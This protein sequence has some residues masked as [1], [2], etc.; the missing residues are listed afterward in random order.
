MKVWI[1]NIEMQNLQEILEQDFEDLYFMFNKGYGS[2]K[3][4][5]KIVDSFLLNETILKEL[6]NFLKEHNINKDDI[7]SNFMKPFSLNRNNITYRWILNYSNEK[8]SSLNLRKQKGVIPFDS[9]LIQTP[10]MTFIKN[11]FLNNKS[12]LISWETG[13]WKTA[14]VI[15]LLNEINENPIEDF[16]AKMYVKI[17]KFQFWVELPTNISF[18]LAKSKL[19]ECLKNDK[20]YSKFKSIEEIN[21]VI[22]SNPFTTILEKLQNNILFTI[23]NP[24]EYNFPLGSLQIEQIETDDYSGQIMNSL[25]NNPNLVYIS[26]IRRQSEY[27]DFLLASSQGKQIIST[28]HSDWVFGNIQK[29][30]SYTSP[31]R[32]KQDIIMGVNW[33]L[34]FKRYFA[35]INIWKDSEID[36]FL[37]SY[38]FLYLNEYLKW[39]LNTTKGVEEFKQL[40]RARYLSDYDSVGIYLDHK[41]S[42]TYNLYIIFKKYWKLPNF[43]YQKKN[44]EWVSD[45]VLKQYGNEID[46]EK[47]GQFTNAVYNNW[48]VLI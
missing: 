43:I 7:K 45:M 37:S 5:G 18:E 29:I 46:D 27:E 10:L 44:L 16:V 13:S 20:G 30:I 42:L 24:I 21:R 3:N 39:L 12:L 9:Y 19:E 32:A 15:S 41:I 14:F 1:N 2:F 33:F 4:N 47:W 8:L 31:E 11:L 40:T 28:N 48:N 26:E 35:T 25:R 22:L 36:V 38:E 17:L 6:D 34:N 23:E